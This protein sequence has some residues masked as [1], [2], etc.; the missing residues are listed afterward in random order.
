[1]NKKVFDIQ[2]A[3][4]RARVLESFKEASKDDRHGG[5]AM[6]I[7]ETCRISPF[8][9]LHSIVASSSAREKFCNHD[10]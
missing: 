7:P 8:K 6:A 3:R 1:M 9:L 4:R 5:Q 10:G 2:L